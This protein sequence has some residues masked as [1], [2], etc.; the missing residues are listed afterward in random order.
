MKR[1]LIGAVVVLLGI[2]LLAAGALL[3]VDV[4][5]LRPQVQTMLSKALGR[6]V[7]VGRLHAAL[8]SGSLRTDDIRIG[9][10][11][12]FGTQTFITARS[13]ELGVRL[14]P[15]LMQREL[16]ITSLRLDQPDV[17]LR[18]DREGG[19]NFARLGSADRVPADASA[20][21]AGFTV[22][23]LRITDG[24]IALER[25]AGDTRSYRQVQ[26]SAD[27]VDVHSG[28][29]FTLSAVTAGNGT[30]ALEGTVGRWE[31]GHAL[32]TPLDAHLVMRDLDLVGA[33]LMAGDGGV[34]GVLDL[35]ARVH[36]AQGVLQSQ[37]H[38]EAR[39]LKLVAAGS[40]A[41]RPVRIDYGASYR[42][43]AGRGR[44]EHA[45]L[46]SG[47]AR[48]AVHGDFDHRPRITQLDLRVAGRQ[49]PIDDLQPL[50]PAFGMVLPKGSRL[51]GGTADLDLTV[52]GPLDALV[53]RGPV[54]LDRS[55]LANYSL[56]AKL[57]G[58]LALAGVPVPKDTVIR[59]AEAVLVI[60]PAGIQADPLRADIVGL[61]SLAGKGRMAA[62]G[63]LDFRLLVK[64]DK[65]LAGDG[66]G[67]QGVAGSLGNSKAGRVLGGVL[68]GSAQQGVGVRVTG[69]AS[70]PHFKLDPAAVAGLLQAGVAGPKAGTGKS[71]AITPGKSVPRQDALEALLRGAL[72]SK[73]EPPSGHK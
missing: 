66:A 65:T 60:A 8:W 55:R 13:L 61:G 32:R 58:A 19:W 70:A 14:W 68:S 46:G 50:L 20:R 16:Q 28:F 39:R 4:D 10:D 30:L 45:T 33:G 5:R 23:Q 27:R 57:G 17:H 25:A 53:I 7:T 35:D 22:D 1:L 47:A 44:I 62:D 9:D 63:T 42:L 15:L 21:P 2:V 73:K 40:P 48:L 31:L 3:V 11:P 72:E 64:L 29:P 43:D 59:H 56:G 67:G 41:A 26:L 34:G 18:Q 52:R 12:A 24:R 54:A 38:I 51:T 37:G 6:E 71:D 36:S 69:T 49:Q